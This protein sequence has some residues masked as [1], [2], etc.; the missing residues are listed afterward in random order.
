MVTVCP[1]EDPG[2][3]TDMIVTGGVEACEGCCGGINVK[4]SAS[5]VSILLFCRGVGNGFTYMSAFVEEWDCHCELRRTTR[6]SNDKPTF[7]GI[8]VRSRHRVHFPSL[9]LP[10]SATPTP[11]DEQKDESRQNHHGGYN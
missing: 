1:A 3:E 2:C 8:V 4:G 10:A 6:P 11:E 7:L 5:G 9:R